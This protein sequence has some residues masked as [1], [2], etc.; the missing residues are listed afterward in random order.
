[1]NEEEDQQPA[2]R[3]RIREKVPF[4]PGFLKKIKVWNFTTYSYSEFVLSP[5]LNMIIGPNGSGKSTLVAAICI[6]LA[7]KID[8][9]KRKNLKSMIKTGHD[10]A[11]VEIT[12]ENV[13]GKP[14][15]V[16]KRDFSAKDSVWTV[17]NKKSTENAVKELRR[18]FNI[19]LDNLCHFLP[20]ERV[21][22]FAAMSPE[23]L[24]METERTLKDGQLL[25]LHEDLID[26]DTT[27]QQYQKQI[28]ALN[29]RLEQLISQRSQLEEEVQKLQEYDNK[30]K[31]IENHRALLPYAKYNDLKKQRA[32]LRENLEQA[33]ARYSSFDKNFDPLRGDV[34]LLEDEIELEKR[35]LQ[36]ITKEREGVLI[37]IGRYK[38][39]VTKV[40][41]SISDSSAAL[42]SYRAKS[43]SKKREL[44]E[45]R[46]ELANLTNQ[47]EN[48][49][50]VDK[51]QLQILNNKYAEARAKL[52]ET[53]EK[54]RDENNQTGD[55]RSDLNTLAR[56]VQREESKLQGNDKLELLLSAAQ[57]K[58]YRLR[59]ESFKAHRKLR[60]TT[61]LNLTYF[62]APIISCNVS[63]K[64]I[65]PAMEK[66]IDNN[67]L[68][69]LTTTTREGYDK[70][71][72]FSKETRLNIPLRMVENNELPRP[73]YSKE[74]LRSFGFDGYLSDFIVGPKEVLSMLYSTS[75]IN[76]IP[77][78]KNQLSPQQVDKLTKSSD[79]PFKKFVAGD[80]LFN[81]RTSKYGSKQ[82]Y[83]ESEKFGKSQFF[84]V[85]GISEQDKQRINSNIQRFNQEIS[86]KRQVYQN[87]KAEI[88]QYTS[89]IRSIRYEMSEIKNEQ[90]KI[91]SMTTELTSLETKISS[92]KEKEKKLEEDSNK[93]YSRR[94][95]HYEHKIAELYGELAQKSMELSQ[96]Q[97]KLSDTQIKCKFQELALTTLR[98]KLASAHSLMES[99]KSIK[100]ELANDVRKYKRDY[101]QIKDSPE[102]KEYK[103][104]QS[105]LTEE[106]RAHIAEFAKVYLENDTFTEHTI[107]SK[108]SHLEEDLSVMSVGDKG[109]ITSLRA[110]VQDIERAETDLPRLEAEKRALDE[111]I[112]TISTEWD[113]DLTRFVEQISVAF[114]RRFSKVASEG[115]VELAKADRFK[116]WKLQIMVKFRHESELKVLDNQSQSGGERAV[117]TIFYIMSLQGLTHAPF[118]IVDEINQGMDPKNEQMAHRYLVHT[119]CQNNKSQYFLVTPKLLTGLYYHPDMVVHCIFTG[120]MIEENDDRRDTGFLDYVNRMVPV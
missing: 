11:V 116:D 20:Q 74:E 33:K 102:Y 97:T 49:E 59:D 18:K 112:R 26:K 105:S 85:S 41:D 51:E 91:Q 119:A 36:E 66:I 101:D 70:L 16:I 98:N 28:D 42:K 67:T 31:E 44:E 107:R 23:K 86:E 24:L 8:L 114:S 45:V 75:K 120:P 113:R 106:E 103:E 57:G 71:G 5:T 65:A 72:K 63:D 58:S 118:R 48:F 80:T 92:K 82:V 90:Q 64:S 4:Q 95:K 96:L 81:I 15:I 108:I 27:S 94:V 88:E 47:L 2:K 79:V 62:E 35:E 99:L 73:R 100:D 7:G 87:H 17:N 54:L 37:E 10:R 6:G 111:R 22:E 69:A 46:K 52:R 29:Q 30:A 9:I 3:R 76:T 21:A 14:P 19:Q 78:T 117:S 115:R 1:M 43:E 61:D 39:G 12:V 84:S 93:D 32:E 77:V 89:D 34:S 55:L 60:A 83:Y 13:A 25:A 110:K 50:K 40:Q 104:K 68:F 109:S 53:E 38:H 56:N